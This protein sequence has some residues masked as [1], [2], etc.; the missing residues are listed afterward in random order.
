MSR[1]AKTQ[2]SVCTSDPLKD[3]EVRRKLAVLRQILTSCFGPRGRLKQVHN[4]VGGPVLTTSTSAVL[5]KALTPSHPVL[6]LLTASVLNHAARFGD[7]GLFAGILCSA[8]VER[9]AALGVEA[10]TAAGAYR[11]LLGLCAGYLQ[12]DDCGCKVPVDFGSSRCLLALARGAVAAKPACAL[13]P[14]EARH[15]GAQVVRAFLH[16]VPCAAPGP[17]RLGRAATVAV[18]GRPAG[19][20]AVH[21]GLL[22]DAPETLRPA[23]AERLGR[24]PLRLALFSASL[25]GDLPEAGEGTF[26]VDWEVSLEEVV[27]G[28]LMRLGEQVV[29]DGVQVFVCQRVVHP[30]LQQYLRKHGVIVVERLGIALLEPLIQVS[31]AQAVA[32]FQTPVP[33][34]SYGQ[35][36]GLRVLRCGSRELLHLLPVGDPPCCTLLLCHRTETALSEL[37]V[38]CQTAERV[39]RQTLMEPWALLG[40]GCTETH[41][42]AYVGFQS[43]GDASD[44]AAELGCSRAHYL[45]AADAF[46]RALL[47]AARAL[48]HDGGERLMDLSRA[49]CW[50]VPPGADPRAPWRDAVGR[51]GCGL[52]PPRGDLEWSPLGTDHPP[53]SPAPP[54]GM[55]HPP[56][57][58]APPAGTD[59][60]P[61]V[62]DSFAAK[63]NALH[64]A[65]E[66][67]NL[68]LDIK[69]IVQDVN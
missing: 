1:L 49:H 67:A 42:S 55:D 4:N 45:L 29:R 53:F 44:A 24:G 66:T 31:G 3:E 52:T 61:L 2:P 40:G 63:Y 22:V 28:Q 37:K 21:P 27:L 33:V 23:D 6:R 41:L 11:R 15:V 20:T 69:Y 8:L 12:R 59:A 34:Q 51:C 38:A 36:G 13:T 9:A 46:R 56:F 35:L 65:V 32:S 57:S 26:E 14:G 47:A 64:V 43:R 25:A 50:D 62:L 10:A 60:D 58:P 5:L 19:E 48:E 16:T 39:L 30:V 68:I 54:A 7:C 18:E 17:V